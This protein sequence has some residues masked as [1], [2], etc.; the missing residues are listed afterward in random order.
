MF[1]NICVNRN[2]KKIYGPDAFYDLGTSGRQGIQARNLRPG[3]ICIVASYHDKDKTTVKFDWYA[4]ARETQSPDEKGEIRRA[5]R[6]SLKKTEVLSKYE[7]AN[8]PQY[9]NMFSVL[10]HFKRPSVI[11]R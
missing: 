5:L 6:G 10:G 3:D 7:A 2:Y 8:S 9:A 1:F 4:F 11:P